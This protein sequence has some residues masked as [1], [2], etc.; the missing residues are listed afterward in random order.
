MKRV[1][2][3]AAI[4]L[5]VLGVCFWTLSSIEA[6]RQELLP[7][8]ESALEDMAQGKVDTAAEHA[9]RIE[10]TWEKHA[11]IL[12]NFVHNAQ[13]DDISSSVSKLTRLAD[14]GDYPAYAAEIATA[15]ELFYKLCKRERTIFTGLFYRD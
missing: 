7:L 1:Y 15:R 4:L 2:I 13:L 11:D 3:A 10:Q 5:A 6:C 8:L 12:E 9:R 14:L